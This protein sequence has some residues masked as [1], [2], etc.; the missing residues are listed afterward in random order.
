MAQVPWNR[1]LGTASFVQGGVQQQ[2]IVQRH[3][4]LRKSLKKQGVQQQ[5]VQRHESL[6]NIL[7]K[8][9]CAVA[10]DSAKP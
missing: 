5:I 4:N 9:R 10:G 3:G 2:Q 7:Q 6:R 1:E 8:A